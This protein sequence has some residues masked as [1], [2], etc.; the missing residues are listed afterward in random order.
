MVGASFVERPTYVLRRRGS[1]RYEMG[2]RGLEEVRAGR[3]HPQWCLERS[4]IPA[5]VCRGAGEDGGD[6]IR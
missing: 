3:R 6:D 1:R 2:D 4:V 5:S